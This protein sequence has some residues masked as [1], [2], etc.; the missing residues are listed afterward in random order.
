MEVKNIE[1]QIELAI[2]KIRPFIQRDG[3][4]VEFVRFENGIV[5]VRMLGACQG[6]SLLDQTIGDGLEV[7]LMDEVPGVL[8]VELVA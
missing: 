6:C 5:Y 2:G 3:G 4:D 7:V 1:Q 8:G